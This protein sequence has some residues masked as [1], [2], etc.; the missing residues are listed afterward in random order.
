MSAE[1]HDP[2]FD[3]QVIRGMLEIFGDPAPV[4]KVIHLFLQEAPRQV[5]TMTEGLSRGEPEEIRRAAHSLKSSAASLGA[6]D[7]SELSAKVEELT[8][9]QRMDDVRPLIERLR[10]SLDQV[11]AV[12]TSE[13]ERLDP[14]SAGGSFARPAME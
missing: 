4:V 9:A 1:P 7:L 10:R 12:L 6:K 11:T 8:R 5:D 2:V 14:P 13:A 3:P